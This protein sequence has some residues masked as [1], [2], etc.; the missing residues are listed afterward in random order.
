[1]IKFISFYKSVG[2]ESKSKKLIRRN[3]LKTFSYTKCLEYL[4]ETFTKF[5]PDHQYLI[6]T[7]KHTHLPEL[8]VEVVRDDLSKMPMMEAITR[9]NT[10]FVLNNIG[11]IVLAGADHLICGPIENFFDDDF[12]LGFWIFPGFDPSHRISVSMTIVLI[13]KTAENASEIDN[14]FKR[15]DKIC[16]SLEKRERQWFADQKSIS[17]L[18]EEENI[19]SKYHE[20]NGEQS[21]WKFGNLKVKFFPYYEKKYLTDVG[22]DGFVKINPESIL[23]DFPGHKSKEH[24]DKVYKMITEEI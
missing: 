18:L 16:F 24:I 14:F 8:P 22:D 10:N 12:D 1:M 2:S 3:N 17:L 11:K 7:D 19:I 21:I 20:K 9:S 6:A 13:N 5:N 15:R 23:V 4:Y